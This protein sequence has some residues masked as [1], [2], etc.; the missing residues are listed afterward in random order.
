MPT[1]NQRN[2]GKYYEQLR[3]AMES[4]EFFD[5]DPTMIAKIEDLKK[6]IDECDY[7]DLSPKQKMRH[8]IQKQIDA[9]GEVD[10]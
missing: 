2:R 7:N 9:S 1:E 3:D 5:N 8:L 10:E 6:A 4:E